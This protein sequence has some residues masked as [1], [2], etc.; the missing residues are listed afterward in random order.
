MIELWTSII[1]K[2]KNLYMYVSITINHKNI[3]MLKMFTEISK[4]S[5][6]TVKKIYEIQYVHFH[7]STWLFS[8]CNIK[9]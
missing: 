8:G 2:Y 1:S 3:Q 4:I 9:Y 7:A 5:Y 6:C